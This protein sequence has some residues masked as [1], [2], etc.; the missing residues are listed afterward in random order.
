LQPPVPALAYVSIELEIMGDAAV[1]PGTT[2]F[3]ILYRTDLLVPLIAAFLDASG[4]PVPGP[5]MRTGAKI[6]PDRR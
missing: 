6:K 5:I 4:P 2:H 1:L 3:E